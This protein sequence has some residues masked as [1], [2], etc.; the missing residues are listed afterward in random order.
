MKRTYDGQRKTI[1]V[2][3]NIS[4]SQNII[5]TDLQDIDK[6]KI[7]LMC[8]KKKG[9]RVTYKMGKLKFK[10]MGGKIPFGVESYNEKEILNIELFKNNNHHNNTIHELNVISQI[11]EQFS[12]PHKKWEIK[13]GLSGEQS[14][15]Q[16]EILDG[17]KEKIK[18]PFVKLPFDFINDVKYKEFCQST[19]QVYNQNDI[20][21]SI[22]LR[23]HL[24]TRID[25]YKRQNNKLVP[26]EYSELKG[27]TAD[28]E[29]ELGNIWVHDGKYGF[30][31]YVN[32]I[33]IT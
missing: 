24:K 5:S 23:T 33:I 27:K 20:C 19:K 1:G 29:I 3:T 6:E 22:Y 17:L 4:S 31:W 13:N 10:I 16:P 26:I 2:S 21:N 8:E 14:E 25:L 12:K 9:Y 15:M 7:F 30:I 11:Y 32:K 18:L 28:F